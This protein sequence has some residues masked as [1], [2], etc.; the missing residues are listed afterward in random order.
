MSSTGWA[1]L[2]NSPA[3]ALSSGS[4]SSRFCPLYVTAQQSACQ[5]NIVLARMIIDGS[6]VTDEC[7]QDCPLLNWQPYLFRLSL[8]SLDGLQGTSTAWTS[9]NHWCP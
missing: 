7:I 3:L 5:F 8:H 6:A 1:H 2:M 9:L 4:K